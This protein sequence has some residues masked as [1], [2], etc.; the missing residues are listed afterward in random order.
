[1]NKQIKK[2]VLTALFIAIGLLLP[3]IFHNIP[4]GGNIFLP[5]HLPII[6]GGLA[7]GPIYGLAIALCVPILSF[8]WTNMPNITVLPG[9]TLELVTYA[10]ICPILL[11]LIRTKYLYINIYISLIITMFI[12]RVISGLTN[13]FIFQVGNYNLTTWVTLSFITAIPGIIIQL[14]I[15]PNLYILFKKYLLSDII[16]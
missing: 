2:L 10:I 1:M 7:L 8:L 3:F 12:G 16:N 14:I 11:K 13:A 4:S 6:L 5:M 9:M 15:I